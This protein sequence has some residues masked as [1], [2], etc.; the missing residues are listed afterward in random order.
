MFK[1]VFGTAGLLNGHFHGGKHVFLVNVLF[2]GYGIGHKN[3][4]GSGHTFDILHFVLLIKSVTNKV[5]VRFPDES[6]R[7]WQEA[8]RLSA[9]WLSTRQQTE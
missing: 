4:F 9:V 1:T 2:S 6:P 7:T 8:R 5:T 3:N